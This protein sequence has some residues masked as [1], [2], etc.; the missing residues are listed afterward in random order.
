MKIL[1]CILLGGCLFVGCA[2]SKPEPIDK[3]K[4]KS[5]F[6]RNQIASVDQQIAAAEARLA[7]YEVSSNAQDRAEIQ[8]I[9]TEIF[10]LKAQKIRL[11]YHTDPLMEE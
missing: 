9:Q 6:I 1:I 11:E 3:P 2:T 10:S 8:K 7:K 5:N 4:S